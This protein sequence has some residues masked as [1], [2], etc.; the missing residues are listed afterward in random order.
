[1]SSIRLQYGETN[2]IHRLFNLLKIKGLYMFRALLAHPQGALHQRHL[3]YCVR[4]MTVDCT[5][6][7]V[8]HSNPV[9]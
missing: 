7:E 6:I 3:V 9:N 2:V 5:R 4:D 1:M 8:F